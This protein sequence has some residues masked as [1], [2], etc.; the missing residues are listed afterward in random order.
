MGIQAA[1]YLDNKKLL[2]LVCTKMSEDVKSQWIRVDAYL[3]CRNNFSLYTNAD[4]TI[5]GKREYFELDGPPEESE[6]AQI[7]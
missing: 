5:E 2:D 3:S 6:S 7:A 1:N 4:L